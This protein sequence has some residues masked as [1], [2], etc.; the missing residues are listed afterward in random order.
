MLTVAEVAC[1]HEVSVRTVQ[2]AR[3]VLTS[4]QDDLIEACRTGA[5]AVSAAAVALR[6]GMTPRSRLQRPPPPPRPH[7][8]PPNPARRWVCWRDE[9][10][11]GRLCVDWCGTLHAERW[12]AEGCRH[13]REAWRELPHYTAEVLPDGSAWHEGAL[14]LWVPAR[15]LP[16]VFHAGRTA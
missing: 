1:L 7:P 13:A 8:A 12:R 5:L 6:E 2:D 10:R 3:L 4:G 14:V 15:A 9:E 16:R 11:E